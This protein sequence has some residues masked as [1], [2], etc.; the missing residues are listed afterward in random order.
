QPD[1][2]EHVEAL[3]PVM[4]RSM[5]ADHERGTGTW[6]GEWLALPDIVVHAASA[7]ATM[8]ELAGGLVVDTRRMRANLD[9]TGGLVMAE[10]AMMALAPG[11]GRLAAHD[12]VGRACAAASTQGK[13]LK[14]ILGADQAVREAL[15]AGSLEQL[16]DPATYTGQ[17]GA[18][19]DR[20]LAEAARQQGER[21]SKG[22]RI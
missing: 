3:L 13:H 21:D 6:H 5:A 1:A 16:F 9:L 2:A 10:A 4:T 19:V 18:F 14:D 8:R 11:L 7:L 15:G 17:A 12:L 22:S 20:V